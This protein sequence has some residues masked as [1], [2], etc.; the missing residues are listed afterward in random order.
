MIEPFKVNPDIISRHAHTGI[1]SPKVEFNNLA[2]RRHHLTHSIYGTDAATATNFGVIFIAPFPCYI[3][4]IQEVHQTA[5]ND[6]GDVGLT[7]EKLTGTQALDAGVSLLSGTISLKA[8]ANTVQNG[9]LTGTLTSLQMNIGDRLALKDTGTLTN[10]VNVTVYT[11][12]TY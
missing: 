7:I 10:V 6:A 12:I 4:A 5:G 9:T 3:S 1:D 8:T 11:E 2:N